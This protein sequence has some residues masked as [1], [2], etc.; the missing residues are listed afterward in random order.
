MAYL[1]IFISDNKNLYTITNSYYNKEYLFTSIYPDLLC[2][3][4]AM[5]Y[6]KPY[7]DSIYTTKR[8]KENIVFTPGLF[9]YIIVPNKYLTHKISSDT[10]FKILDKDNIHLLLYNEFNDITSP[11]H[12]EW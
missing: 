9:G 12:L 3:L 8:S 10:I 4:N 1:P 2:S 6:T 7:I 11:I 5:V